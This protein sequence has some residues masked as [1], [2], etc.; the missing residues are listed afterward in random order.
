MKTAWRR[1]GVTLAKYPSIVYVLDLH[2]DAVQDANGTQYKL[3][4]AEDPA[5]AQV[6]LIMGVARRL[7]G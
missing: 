3:V 1:S 5:A 7:A 4:T 2:R 6:S